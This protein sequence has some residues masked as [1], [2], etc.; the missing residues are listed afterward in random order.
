MKKIYKILSV[1]L[2]V[3]YLIPSL[4][5]T[6]FASDSAIR[7]YE[8]DANGNRYKLADRINCP[9]VQSSESLIFESDFGEKDILTIEIYD[10]DNQIISSS[11]YS[12]NTS[13]GS[14]E[15][16]EASYIKAY[17]KRENVILDSLT[18][19][20]QDSTRLDAEN[21][22]EV[23][24]S[25]SEDENA[26]NHPQLLVNS[27]LL[28][29]N[30]KG[31]IFEENGK[32]DI[33]LEMHLSDEALSGN[34][35][36][37]ALLTDCNG[38]TVFSSDTIALHKTMFTSFSSGTLSL[39]DYTVTV[40]LTDIASGEVA[41]RDIHTVRK[42]SGSMDMMKS[43]I[44]SKGRYI[45][46]G[47]PHFFV[48]VYGAPYSSN[49]DQITTFGDSDAVDA[50]LSYWQG[51]N[52]V[53]SPEWYNA[54]KQRSLG[55]IANMRVFA[56]SSGDRV[57]F[58][59]YT[60]ADEKDRL[61]LWTKHQRSY[62]NL[63]MYYVGDEEGPGF[64]DKLRWHSD[65]ISSHDL[66]R[67]IIYIDWRAGSED[68]FLRSSAA[69]IVGIDYY[70]IQSDASSIGSVAGRLRSF[71][72]GVRNRPVFMV[73]QCANYDSINGN[74]DHDK[75]KL[76]PSYTHLMNMAMQSVCVGAN[77][78]MWYSYSSLMNDNMYTDDEK[79][80][81]TDS[82]ISVS[83]KIKGFSDI[84]LSD[85]EVPKV[86]AV[87]DGADFR[88]Y[89]VRHFGGKTYIFAVNT[90][91]SQKTVDFELSEM[92]NAK[93]ALSS[94][95]ASISTQNN[96]ATVNFDSLG[97]AVIEI[98]QARY[99]SADC[100]LHAM[101]LNKG[102]ESIIYSKDSDGNIKAVIPEDGEISYNMDIPK[103]ATVY[104]NGT[105]AN[106][107]GTIS[108]GVTRFEIVAPDG[109]SNGFNIS[110]SVDTPAVSSDVYQVSDKFVISGVYEYTNADTFLASL[111]ADSGWS[112]KIIS[113][114][115]FTDKDIIDEST[116]LE[117]ANPDGRKQIYSVDLCEKTVVTT[118]KN[119]TN[120]TLPVQIPH[121]D[122]FRGSLIIELDSTVSDVYYTGPEGN[123]ALYISASADSV[124]LGLY[125]N[126]WK[127]T[128]ETDLSLGDSIKITFVVRAT[129]GDNQ[130]DYYIN[131]DYTGTCSMAAIKAGTWTK[132]RINSGTVASAYMVENLQ[133]WLDEKTK[134]GIYN[135]GAGNIHIGFS[136]KKAESFFVAI[137][138]G[139][140]LEK[141]LI[142]DLTDYNFSSDILKLPEDMNGKTAKAFIWKKGVVPLHCK[143]L[144]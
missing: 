33:G 56:E 37:E 101:S 26:S 6:V 62:D 96:T 97:Y 110:C 143:I 58:K 99:L 32:D 18:L 127:G 47:K 105:A 44:D 83:N 118:V 77:G 55:N 80:D 16:S 7:V 66:S 90:S 81:V 142:A 79:K 21:V 24:T 25:S 128:K 13:L 12:Q 84:I 131:G 130:V 102:T 49:Q 22:L 92:L 34:Y 28:S 73:I 129:Q 74:H 9:F 14:D 50:V 132:W 98:E 40:K 93:L 31:L 27:V 88:N 20:V 125:E 63:D 36:L 57:N 67:P 117:A 60:T 124:K 2:A 23:T 95:D 1:I 115:S 54:L 141:V 107:Y 72:S 120:L 46:E 19:T 136:D 87:S 103:D 43:Y 68:G 137:Y 144:K 116:L 4:T 61:S 64:N 109:S 51:M 113:D 17:L 11:H 106:S 133:S 53:Y 126:I 35:R 5:A 112:M 75:S 108:S 71:A 94:D 91:T 30:Y 52:G 134:D 76:L 100:A 86:S 111:V 15:L 139:N 104:K 135:D 65:I 114:S 85:E 140:R 69:D 41:D 39:G 70:P 3:I 122:D 45:K 38:N 29:P 8:A 42:R 89:T 119:S 10:K 82:V 123:N 78:I 59:V 48:G 121:Y 138:E